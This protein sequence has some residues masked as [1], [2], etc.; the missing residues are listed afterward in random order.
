MQKSIR[1]IDKLIV[2]CSILPTY[3]VWFNKLV[4]KNAKSVASF[5][6]DWFLAT[7][8]TILNVTAG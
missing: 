5:I 4:R 7:V 8:L 1:K 6:K 2:F 3:L